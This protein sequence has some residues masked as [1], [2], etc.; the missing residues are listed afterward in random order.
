MNEKFMKLAIEEAKKSS[1]G[2]VCGAVIVKDGE[3]LAK[4]HNTQRASFDA[5]AHAEINAIREAGK[6]LKNKYLE[7]CT[8]YCTCEPCIMCIA[9]IAF[10]RMERIVYGLTLKKVF[11]K[12][13]LF[14]FDSD[15]LLSRSPKKIEVIK[16]FMEDECSQLL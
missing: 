12:E 3:V 2:M 14:D 9:A 1:E 5:S 4:A 8:I 10:A 15:V 13:R 7:G 16:N 11:P 6:K